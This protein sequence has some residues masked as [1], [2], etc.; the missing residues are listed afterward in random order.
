MEDVIQIKKD[1]ILRVKII[2]QFGNDTGNELEFDL[3]DIE[4]P[5]RINMANR[6]HEKNV[7][8]FH[9]QE[10][11]IK[12][13]PDKKGKYALS[14]NQECLVKLYKEFYEKEMKVLDSFL[15]EGG[16]LKLLNGRK[17]YYTM[18][19]DFAEYLKPILPR[20]EKT[21]EQ[22]TEKIKKQYGDKKEDVLQ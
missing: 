18:F 8:Y 12:K 2:D 4:L 6:E 3:E 22:I 15:G 1:N 21:K 20:I 5:L 14:Y 10:I 16:S 7:Q 19:D 17:P 11:L 13:R 9:A